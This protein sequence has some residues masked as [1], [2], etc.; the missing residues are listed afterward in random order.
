MINIFMVPTNKE[1]R[2]SY[3]IGIQK[4]YRI[5]DIQKI[6]TNTNEKAESMGLVSNTIT[7][8][9]NIRTDPINITKDIE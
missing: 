7:R 9:P 6:R 4:K 2:G 8:P 1:L 5:K 3:K